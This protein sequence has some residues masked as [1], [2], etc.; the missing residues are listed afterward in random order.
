MENDGEGEGEG[1][2]CECTEGRG[3]ALSAPDIAGSATISPLG[4]RFGGCWMRRLL[5]RGGNGAEFER[6]FAREGI[7]GS[8][9]AESCTGCVGVGSE[10]GGVYDASALYDPDEL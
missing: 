3:T 8:A 2:D 4:F 9:P 1:T 10:E 7:D 5:P 6:S